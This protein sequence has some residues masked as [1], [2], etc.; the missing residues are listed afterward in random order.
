MIYMREN[1]KKSMALSLTYAE[2][3][4]NKRMSEFKD[5]M[6][7]HV[8]FLCKCELSLGSFFRDDEMGTTVL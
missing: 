1:K 7:S 4:V 6:S 8:W 5:D 3:Y 2:D